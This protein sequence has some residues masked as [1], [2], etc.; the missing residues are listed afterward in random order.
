MCVP[1]VLVR[2]YAVPQ[3]GGGGDGGGSSSSDPSRRPHRFFFGQVKM[4]NVNINVPIFRNAPGDL[5]A[6]FNISRMPLAIFLLVCGLYIYTDIYS[7][8][9][10]YEQSRLALW[11]DGRRCHDRHWC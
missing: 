2:V 11:C 4:C 9:G 3:C 1:V 7:M 6:R 8:L 5:L 10:M